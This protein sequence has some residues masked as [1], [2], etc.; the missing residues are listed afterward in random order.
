LC[1]LNA[2]RVLVGG[3]VRYY[4]E[5]NGFDLG[6]AASILGCARSKISRIENGKCGF[7]SAE[8]RQLLTGYGVGTPAQ[9]MLA[10][11]SGWR[12]SDG[13]WHA[14]LESLPS[15]YLAYVIPETLASRSLMYAPNQVP[16]LLRIREYDEA[17]I[18]ADPGI[19][20]DREDV[21]VRATSTRQ[22]VVLHER[23]TRLVVII[24]E[25]ALRQQVG[26]PEVLGR[27]L[28]HL[29]EL[30]SLDYSRISIRV[31]PFGAGRGTRRGRHRRVLH[32]PV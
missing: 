26:G 17:V 7:R 13:W 4:R 27:Q 21:A 2:Q 24:G 16:D 9:D 22:Q 15:A 18:A 3:M 29:A 20:R 12:E 23:R 25:T 6:D 1:V 30:A 19:H 28:A 8:L 11:L 14:Y 32:P 10:A 5:Q 31:L